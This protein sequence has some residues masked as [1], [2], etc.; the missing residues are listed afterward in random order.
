MKSFTEWIIWCTHIYRNLRND[1][2]KAQ[3]DYLKTIKEV[4]PVNFKTA[5]AFA[6]IPSRY[7]LE[8][9]MWKEAAHLEIRPT[10]FP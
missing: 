3:W 2:A 9:K 5:Y 8:N 4:Y 10:D 6:A 1:L 7:V